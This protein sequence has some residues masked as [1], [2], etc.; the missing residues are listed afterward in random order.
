MKWPNATKLCRGFA[1]Q[2]IVSLDFVRRADETSPLRTKLPLPFSKRTAALH[3]L[4]QQ[5]KTARAAFEEDH[6]GEQQPASPA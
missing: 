3:D 4:H 5:G 1:L 6:K 2:V